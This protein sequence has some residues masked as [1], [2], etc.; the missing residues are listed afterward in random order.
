[1]FIDINDNQV[2]TLAQLREEYTEKIRSGEI[3]ESEQNFIQY[4]SNCR[5][6]HGG[7]LEEKTSPTYKCIHYKN[8]SNIILFGLVRP[9]AVSAPKTLE[10][11]CIA[12][13][14]TGTE[15]DIFTDYDPCLKISFTVAVE[16]K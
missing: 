7:T 11:Y 3:E 2:V 15:Y 4:V 14:Q 1:M 12:K 9:I 13:D 5:T 10:K 16:R 8:S 6:E